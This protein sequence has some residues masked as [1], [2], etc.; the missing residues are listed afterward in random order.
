MPA[1]DVPKT[2]LRER[3]VAA[4]QRALTAEASRSRWAPLVADLAAELARVPLRR[5]VDREQLS[6]ALR[7]SLERANLERTT[8]PVVR[9]LAR[10]MLGRLQLRPEPAGSFVPP[11]AR[12]RLEE[13]VARDDF[14]SPALVRELTQDPAV[15][16]V[17]HEVLLETLRQFSVKANPFT[18]DWGLPALLKH[19]PPFGFGA[20]KS[21]FEARRGEFEARIEP[22]I[23]KFLQGFSRRA[24][25]QVTELTL[26][27]LGQPEFVALRQRILGA[28]LDR[29]V[30]EL[31]WPPDDARTELGLAAVLD[32]AAAACVHELWLR[33]LE[34]LLDELLA[35]HGDETL[36]ELCAGWGIEL[37]EPR[38]WADAWWPVVEAA[39]GSEAVRTALD[40]VVGE[41][42]GDALASDP[43]EPE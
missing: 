29:S 27:R 17:I 18:A 35:A 24:V 10:L 39:L 4:L 25:Q 9:Q 1:Q 34:T 28:L 15:E 3:L 13:L 7:C 2:E 21:A 22:E 20:I 31:A 16:G 19:L 41:A 38:A 5:L 42:L 11:T 23:R 43:P 37:P 36:A 8:L 14:F 26:R 32:I 12:A 40:R 33:E 30:R 6:V